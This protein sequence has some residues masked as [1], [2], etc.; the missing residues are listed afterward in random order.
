MPRK[1]YTSDL[2]QVE[3]EHIERI[4]PRS[5][6]NH[7]KHNRKD[8]FDG[9]MY[10]LKNAC[11]WRDI[12]GDLPSGGV[13]NYHFCKYKKTGYWELIKIEINKQVRTILSKANSTPTC[14]LLDSQSVKNTD[15][16][17]ASGIDGNKKIKG[18]KRNVL[19]DTI[20]LNWG[21]KVTPANFSDRLGG[22]LVLRSAINNTP[23]CIL[24]K[25][26]EGYSGKEFQIRCKQE[27]NVTL[28]I[29][30]KIP[31]QIGF[32]VLPLRW[33]VER[34][35]AWM[36]KCRRL[37]KNCERLIDTSEN[38]VHICFLRIALHKLSR[39]LG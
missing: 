15:T 35:N 18:V 20:G 1:Q 36:D 11:N 27:C 8:I 24:V 28:E 22:R 17:C 29:V 21:I 6:T 32:Q 30:K 4:L 37:W 39:L 10:L 2:T 3:F 12:P 13:C 5:T 16:G 25:A 19:V 9:I 34:S 23:L 7:C 14:L 38:M 31:D 26:D 33:V